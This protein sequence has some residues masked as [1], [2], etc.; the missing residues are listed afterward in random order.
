MSAQLYA[1]MARRGDGRLVGG[2]LSASSPHDALDEL[3][4]RALVVTALNPAGSLKGALTGVVT[5][6]S[7][8]ALA[9]HAFFRAFATLVRNGVPVGRALGLAGSDCADRRLAEALAAVESSIRVGSSLSGAMANRPRQFA[10]LLVTIIRAGE[11]AGRLEESLE[12]IAD[13][14]DRRRAMQRRLVSALAYPCIVAIS[15]VALVIFLAGS[16]LPTIGH[17]ALSLGAKLPPSTAFIFWCGSLLIRPASWIVGLVCAICTALAVRRLLA[18]DAVATTLEAVIG[19]T[20]IVGRIVRSSATARLSRTLGT[21]LAAGVEI[22]EALTHSADAVGTRCYRSVIERTRESIAEG[23]SLASVLCDRRLFDPLFIQLVKIGEESG[24]LDRMLLQIAAE[25]EAQAEA[26]LLA[27]S[28]TLE[29]FLI[30]I[31]GALVGGI[32]AAVLMP[33]YS[34]IGSIR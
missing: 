34:L 13:L 26:S 11:A 31:L 24:S 33:L 14:F 25:S 22:G 4:G 18:V 10:P 12:S 32:V 17:L 5:P 30:L 21:L 8:N 20:P 29:P 23:A 15:A 7:G 9:L 27:L 6:G 3:R 2:T 28:T 1:Y 16:V 19:Q